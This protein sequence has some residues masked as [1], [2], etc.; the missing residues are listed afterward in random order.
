MV[1]Y[2]SPSSVV[3]PKFRSP[4]YYI[5]C[6]KEAASL[7][8]MR[9]KLGAV[10]VDSK[11]SIIACGYN[12][13]QTHPIY[14][15]KKDTYRYISNSGFMHAEGACLYD[16]KKKG[17]QIQD[18][19]SCAMFVYRASWNLSKPC[20]HC[21]KLL[22]DFGVK[23]VYYTDKLTDGRKVVVKEEYIDPEFI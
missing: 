23:T 19:S 8:P 3:K 16:A 20:V 2:F 1:T 4:Q 7:S 6:A 14:G 15:T 10:L 22:V 18:L 5:D 21:Q 11:G 17:Y 9:R 12:S 13:Y